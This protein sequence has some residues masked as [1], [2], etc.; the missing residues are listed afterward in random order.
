MTAAGGLMLVR[1]IVPLIRAAI[2]RGAVKAVGSEDPEELIAEGV[3]MAAKTLD[4]AEQRCKVVAPASL[5]YYAI[6]ALKSGRRSGYAGRQDAMCPAVQLDRRV[7]MSSMDEQICQDLETDSEITLHDLLAGSGE[8]ADITAARH[9]D[10]PMVTERLNC[11]E[12]YV[13]QGT[14]LET[15]GITMAKRLRVT[16]PRVT[17]IK[18][19]VAGKIRT[20]WG[21]D[22]LRDAVREPCWHSQ[23]RATAER[24]A[25]RA[26]RRAA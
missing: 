18:R 16:T 13:V 21:E 7:T 25:C 23:M 22:A 6:Q 14:A 12:S 1:Q 26:G 20:A 11:R 10:W 24:R 9:L 3:A 2:R 19:G 15:P 8:S 4:A 5:A 17:Q